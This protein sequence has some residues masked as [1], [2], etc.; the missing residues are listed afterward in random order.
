MDSSEG[1]LVKSLSTSND[2]I[3]FSDV[4]IFVKTVMGAKMARYVGIQEC[5]E[6]FS[7]IVVV[8]SN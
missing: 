6:E 5:A 2:T 1:I 3:N 8:R 4:R 7:Q